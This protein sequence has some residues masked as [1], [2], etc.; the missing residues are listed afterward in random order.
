[1]R[2]FTAGLSTA[3]EIYKWEALSLVSHKCCDKQDDRG[4]F[5]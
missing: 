5:F 2:R 4:S 3:E 1:M